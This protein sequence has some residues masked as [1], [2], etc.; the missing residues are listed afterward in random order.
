VG[1]RTLA[2]SNKKYINELFWNDRETIAAI[3]KKHIM[4]I[5]QLHGGSEERRNI[6]LSARE[7]GVGIG[8]LILL[9]ETHSLRLLKFAMP[10]ILQIKVSQVRQKYLL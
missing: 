6:T 4:I 2:G 3:Y 1:D 8:K 5:S 10:K 7:N 9:L